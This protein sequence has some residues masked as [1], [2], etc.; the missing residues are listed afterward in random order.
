VAALHEKFSVT[1]DRFGLI[2][3]SGAHVGAT[4][5]GPIPAD[6]AWAEA[7]FLICPANISPH[8]NHEVL[9]KGVMQWGCRWPLVLTGP[10][11]NFM[12]RR[13]RGQRQEAL[14]ALA[15]QG[16]VDQ[17]SLVG[18]GYVPDEL[19]YSLLKRSRALV[20]PTLAEG[21]GSFPVYEALINAVPV[22]CS[23]IP[24]LRE[25][26]QR[27]NAEVLWFDPFRPEELAQQLDNLETNYAFYKQ[28]ACAQVSRLLRRSW[29]DV[30]EDYW[31]A[32][33]AAAG[34]GRGV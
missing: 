8:K 14:R 31:G 24:V 5:A 2:P 34:E 26:M 22:L 12:N 3:L 20:M 16:F 7:P 25:Q 23:D 1:R 17:V 19:Y 21:G 27:L 29:Q 30:A 33:S 15:E 9:L 32:L 28:R 4:T 11:T 10:D 6:W 13:V 18:L